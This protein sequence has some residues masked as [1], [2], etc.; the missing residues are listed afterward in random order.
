[1]TLKQLFQ[2]I[3]HEIYLYRTQAQEYRDPA[4]YRYGFDHKKEDILKACGASR[5]KLEAL[6]DLINEKIRKSDSWT[7][8]RTVEEITKMYYLGDMNLVE[9]M[10]MFWN[11]RESGRSPH[12]RL[13]ELMSQ[14]T[15]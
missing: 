6:T 7:L 14:I 10:F 9:A 12:A 15:K 8:S 2:N 1:M 5:I 11:A 3:S 13:V 4:A